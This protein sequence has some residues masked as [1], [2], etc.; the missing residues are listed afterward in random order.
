MSGEISRETRILAENKTALRL[1]KP[2]NRFLKG[3]AGADE[4]I[5][6]AYLFITKAEG[7]LSYSALRLKTPL[8][9]HHYKC[10]SALNSCVRTR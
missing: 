7:H 10:L 1:L 5:R 4:Q 3:L 8:M 9:C 2:K 6:T